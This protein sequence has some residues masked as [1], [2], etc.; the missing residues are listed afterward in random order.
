MQINAVDETSGYVYFSA[1]PDNAT[2]KYLY[3][4]KLDGSGKAERLSPMSEAGTHDY[5]VSPNGKAAT[6][7]FSN[8]Y[9]DGVTKWFH[10]PSI[11][12]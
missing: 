11:K 6:H 2:Q 3:R 9:T 8:Y 5:D 1:S 4:T 10:C 7:A 12:L